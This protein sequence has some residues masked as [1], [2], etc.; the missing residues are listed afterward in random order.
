[1]T[2]LNKV[3]VVIEGCHDQT[4]FDMYLTDD[5][6]AF[7]KQVAV[8]STMASSCDCQPTIRLWPSRFTDGEVANLKTA[9][10][11]ARE[12]FGPSTGRTGTNG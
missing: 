1:M 6:L 3:S 11:A 9:E 7:M 8:A 10:E 4:D 12:L 2:E 5:Q